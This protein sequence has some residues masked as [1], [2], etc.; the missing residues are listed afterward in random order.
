MLRVVHKI[1]S[2][3]LKR[4]IEHIERFMTFPHQV[5]EE[6]FLNLISKGQETAWGKHYGYGEIKNLAAFQRQV[7]IS[8]YE[9]LYPWIERA[10]NGEADI[11]WPGKTNW[12]S[13]SSGTT[14]DK[15]KYIPVTL[16]SLEN[17][18]FKAGQDVLSV[19]LHN[20]PESKLFSGKSLSIG[21]SHEPRNK[22]PDI[23]FGD[24]SA[25]ITENLPRFYELVRTPSREVA[26]MTDWEAKM[27][28]MAAEILTEDVT[29][30]TGVPT[31]T[32]VLLHYL[33]DQLNLPEQN[34]LEIWP[35]LELYLHGGVSFEPYRDQFR[36]LIPSDQMTYLDCYNA[37]EGFFGFQDREDALDLLLLLDHGV[38]Y[39]FL[40]TDALGEEHPN[41][42][43][44]QEVEIGRN[45]A[46][47]IS[48]NGGLWRYKI[49][50]T[51]QFT[52]TSPYRFKITGRTQ[53]FINAFGE[54]LMVDN[55]EMAISEACRST[56]SIVG[57]YTVAPIYLE[58]K[59]KGGHEWLIEFEQSPQNIHLFQQHLDIAL[60]QVNS[61][62]EAKRQK[63][64]ALV[65]PVIHAVPN[66]TFHQWMKKRGKLGGQHKV[67]RLANHRKYVEDILQDL[68]PSFRQKKS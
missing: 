49:G 45:Y 14:N 67:P 13:K 46:V 18:H 6:V 27:E 54:E 57:N 66:G 32:L 48:T 63:G 58:G 51:I 36:Q 53:Q 21:G 20:N 1:A 5:Q 16:E 41:T 64:L 34:L 8:S 61:D 42:H 56:S 40:P 7:P 44:L 10:F 24:V 47:V 12:F 52:S 31:W 19:Y 30:I 4:R 29:G 60:Q 35:N 26:L 9:Q 11:L 55:A 23:H 68:H 38:F 62:Y 37:S 59:Q 33:I 22:F 3:F 25:V 39:E 15:S 28:A 65:A 50:D 2:W 43:S 17:G